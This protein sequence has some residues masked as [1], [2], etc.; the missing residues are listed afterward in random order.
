MSGR[1]IGR[2]VVLIASV[3]APGTAIYERVTADGCGRIVSRDGA[4]SANFTLVRNKVPSARTITVVVC[5]RWSNCDTVFSAPR[6]AR[7]AMEWRGNAALAIVAN[8]GSAV[9][10]S[11]LSHS[12]SGR[13]P[14]RVGIERR[15]VSA[16]TAGIVF[17]PAVCRVVWPV[18][19]TQ[20]PPR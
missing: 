10:A 6:S 19:S 5:D 18:T 17:D 3:I 2:A 7:V 11:A 14:V 15:R 16:T 12:G 1:S 20:V 8:G 4:Y 13:P 9:A